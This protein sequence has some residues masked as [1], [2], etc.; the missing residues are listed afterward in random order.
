MQPTLAAVSGPVS[1]LLP[2]TG[3]TERGEALTRFLAGR[4]VTLDEIAAFAALPALAAGLA[5]VLFAPSV[6]E[7]GGPRAAFGAP[8]S[9]WRALRWRPNAAWAWATGLLL[10]VC[11]VNLDRVSPFL[12]FQF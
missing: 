7:L 11:L 1:V 3:D 10:A 6:G 8:R 4:P 2:N 9:R 5:I 12:Y